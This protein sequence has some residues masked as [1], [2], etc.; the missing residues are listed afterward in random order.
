MRIEELS[1]KQVLNIFYICGALAF[2][3]IGIFNV[4]TNYIYFSDM[5]LSARVSAITSNIFNFIVSWFFYA[6]YAQN[7]ETDLPTLDEKKAEEI[8]KGAQNGN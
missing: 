8:I 5:I 3:I 6:M 4:Y 7:R 2:L 1:Q